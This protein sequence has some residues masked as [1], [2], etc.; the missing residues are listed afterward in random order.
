MM[1]HVMPIPLTSRGEALRKILQ[2][3]MLLEWGLISL[4]IIIFSPQKLEAVGGVI[5]LLALTF[6]LL[7]FYLPSKIEQLFK[8]VRY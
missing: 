4:A 7:Y 1:Y 3:G 6:L 2:K 5:G 8:K